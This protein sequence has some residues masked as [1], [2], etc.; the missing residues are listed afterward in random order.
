ML[1][2]LY[3]SWWL[4]SAGIGS[5]RRYAAMGPMI[6]TR[7]SYNVKKNPNYTT[8]VFLCQCSS[9]LGLLVVALNDAIIQQHGTCTGA[10]TW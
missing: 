3:R 2:E 4:D 6:D 8:P 5:W 1:P 10:Y 9:V 7:W